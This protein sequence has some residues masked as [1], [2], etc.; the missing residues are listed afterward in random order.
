[1]KKILSITLISAL[2]LVFS[3]GCS[4][5][6]EAAP[7]HAP[8]PEKRDVKVAKEALYVKTHNN[9]KIAHAIEKAGEK[10]GWKITEFKSNEV[11]AEKTTGEETIASTVKFSGGYIEFSDN[12]ATMDL[13]EAIVEEFN[14]SAS[15]H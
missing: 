7:A 3:T 5:K 14:K 6:S 11:I 2:A 9:K 13:R 10:T 4:S 15:S 12:E 8:A 1:M